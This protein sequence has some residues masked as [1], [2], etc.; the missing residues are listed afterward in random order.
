MDRIFGRPIV[1]QEQMRMRIR[2]LGRQITM[3]YT[4]KDLILVGVSKCLCLLCG[5][6]PEPF[7][8]PCGWIF[9]W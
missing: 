2:E 6:W 5:S 4:G 1:T 3:D 9:W 7:E 8:S